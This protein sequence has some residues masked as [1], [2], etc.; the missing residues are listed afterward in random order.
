MIKER[1]RRP[2][3]GFML[4]FFALPR[5]L[6]YF[7]VIA[8]L[9]SASNISYMFF[10][11]QASSKFSGESSIGAP[12]LLY[13]LFN[14]VYAALA[15]PAGIL[16]DRIGRRAV[17]IAGYA[18][19]SIV[20]AFFALNPSGYSLVLLFA[21]YGTVYALVDGVQSAAVSDLSPKST[22]GTSLGVY[23]AATALSSIFSGIVAGWL[24][25]A[26][27]PGHAFMMAS[28]GAAASAVGLIG[29]ARMK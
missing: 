10:I 14:L 21:L 22:R 23:Y 25:Q 16:S 7:I 13:V 19:F 12:L 8:S 4:C 29:L 18:L 24:W 11:L 15:L 2:A 3:K 9:F 6:R 1:S 20:A 26:F 17:L 5:D 27:S 28:A